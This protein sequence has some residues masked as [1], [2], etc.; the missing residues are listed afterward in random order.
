MAYAKNSS[1]F[2]AILLLT[3][4][5]TTSTMEP[6]TQS[7]AWLKWL[8]IKIIGGATSS[9]TTLENRLASLPADIKKVILG[10]LAMTDHATSIQEAS[11]AIRSLSE[12]N[13]EVNQLINDPQFC[14]KIIKHLAKK[15]NCTDETAAKS[16]HTKEAI[17][18]LAIQREA[19]TNTRKAM[20]SLTTELL[21]KEVDANFTYNNSDPGLVQYPRAKFLLMH[22]FP[23]NSYLNKLNASNT[24]FIINLI[25]RSKDV[26]NYPTYFG[27]TVLDSILTHI[28]NTQIYFGEII[29]NKPELKSYILKIIEALL[30]SGADPEIKKKNTFITAQNIAESIGDQD[31]INLINDAIKQK[32]EKKEQG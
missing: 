3:T 26:I 17:H 10:Y 18:R 19:R 32:P 24:N 28:L 14:L 30:N 27:M 11:Q 31:I 12:V 2:I 20:E 23:N 25:K 29:L 1:A 8:G 7:P 5:C 21:S 9:P 15:F 16:L 22:I 13:K 4:I 6:E